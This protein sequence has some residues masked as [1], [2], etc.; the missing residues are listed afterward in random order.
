MIVFATTAGLIGAL[1]GL[2]FKVLILAP[3]IV[4]GS[5]IT[6]A[7]GVEHYNSVWLD[8]FAM[9]LVATALQMGFLSGAA[10]WFLIVSTRIRKGLLGTDT[11]MV[12][13]TAR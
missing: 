12:Q 6:F 1:L 3:A 13:R 11:A 10:I 5:A 9:A 8:L 7:I 2:R 4:L